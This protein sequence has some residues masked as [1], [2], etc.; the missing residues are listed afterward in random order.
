M[1][2]PG[3]PLRCITIMLAGWIGGRCCWL[4]ADRFMPV[5]SASAQPLDAFRQDPRDP[6]PAQSHAWA[7]RTVSIMLD[8]APPPPPA[9][10]AEAEAQWQSPSPGAEIA[11]ALPEPSP[12]TIEPARPATA[13]SSRLSG[14]A[15][16][17][18]RPGDARALAPAGQLGGSQAGLRLRWRLNQGP[19][20]RTALSARLYTPLAHP[21][22]AEAALGAEWHPLPGKPVWIGIERRIALGREGRNVWS[23]YAAGGFWKPGLPAGL[24]LDGYGQAGIV[25]VR[26]REAFADGAL[27]LSRPLGGPRSI[28]LGA[29]IW[30]AAQSELARLD[31]GPRLSLPLRLGK[32]DIPISLEARFRIA[33]NAAPVNGVALTI[34]SDF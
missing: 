9:P 7:G 13:R 18:A 34:G 2:R 29:G 12:E 27:R 3:A 5:G 30:G 10:A 25:E 1:I 28:S 16:L 33:G 19:A 14:S 31:V 6:R 4:Y 23:A 15:W 24:I 11:L 26:Q 21:A 22:G 20:I 32:Q 8:S 17:F